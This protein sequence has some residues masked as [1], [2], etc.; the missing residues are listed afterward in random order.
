MST[1]T[2]DL[3]N[4]I[5]NLFKNRAMSKKQENEIL[6]S[7]TVHS[8][9]GES[10]EISLS[11]EQMNDLRKGAEICKLNGHDFRY[12][13]EDYV[14][15]VIK[16]NW[17]EMAA[18]A[19]NDVH[20]ELKVGMGAT[21]NLYSDRRAMTIVK[22]VSPTEIVVAE[23]K[24]KCLDY[25]AGEYE[26]LPDLAEYMRQ[27]TFTLRKGG[28]WVEKGQP[29]KFGSVTLSVGFQRHYIDPSF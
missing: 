8:R 12:F 18:V 14:P 7:K 3:R 28:T 10:Y 5:I 23:N 27:S 17:P 24:T 9:S 29:K 25:Y 11:Q 2:I 15:I 20:P 6:K 4:I 1:F 26:V 13:L 19:F 16:H 21:M 22:I